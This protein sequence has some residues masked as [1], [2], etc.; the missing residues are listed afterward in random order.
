MDFSVTHQSM[1]VCDTLFE[2]V[3]EQPVELDILLPDYCPDI[4][5]ILVCRVTPCIY[6]KNMNGNRLSVDGKSKVSVIYLDV[7]QCI[8]HYEQTEPFTAEFQVDDLREPYHVDCRVKVQYMNCRAV[9]ERRLDIRGALAV[10]VKIT[11]PAAKEILSG[12]EGGGIQCRKKSMSMNH[13]VGQE[14]SPFNVAETLELPSTKPAVEKIL[15]CEGMA[16]LLDYKVINDK[17]ITKGEIGI[18]ILYLCDSTTGS[19][20]QT[21]FTVPV[22]QIVNLEGVDE[23][24]LCDVRLK[25]DSVEMIPKYDS[26]GENRLLYMDAKCTASGVCYRPEDVEM[27]E[28]A[29]STQ[30][31]VDLEKRPLHMESVSNILS[32]TGHVKENFE[33]PQD[34]VMKIID[35]WCEMISVGCQNDNGFVVT[36]QMNVCM[37]AV[38]QEE[39]PVY[40]ERVM[41]FEQMLDGKCSEPS[42]QCACEAEVMSTSFTMSGG[43]LEI[44]AQLQIN[45]VVFC[46]VDTDVICSITPREDEKREDKRVG[47]T[48]YFAQKG[49]EIWDIAKRYGTRMEDIQNEND[50][51]EDSAIDCRRMLLIPIG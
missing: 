49:E 40:F 24:C 25:L 34:N 4:T 26:E 31:Q 32:Q 22:S 9:S 48:I 3:C 21:E 47:L 29:Y 45:C 51:T 19:I 2:S 7:N 41:D 23:N 13:V 5:R 28:D 35:V 36:G 27:I 50:M 42:C 33:M 39:K 10:S 46:R 6:Q 30:Y 15:R 14:E 1:K 11:S 16:N 8:Q 43:Q 17:I 12:A 20:E 37:L 44:R 18:K 38:D